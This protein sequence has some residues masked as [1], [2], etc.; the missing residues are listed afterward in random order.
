MMHVLA[1]DPTLYLLDQHDIEKGLLPDNSKAYQTHI[2]EITNWAHT[3]L[4]HSHS[5]LGRDGPVCPYTQP[6]LDRALFWLTVFPGPHP[7]LEEVCA[8]VMKYREWFLELE[9]TTGKDAQYK[10]ILI[11][12][13]DL[14]P[15]Q[16]PNVIDTIQSILKPEF[17]S[18][19]LMIGQFHAN[20][21]EPA[22]WNH[23]FHPLRTT[24]PLLAIRYMVP[25]DFPFLKKDASSLAIYLERFGHAV[26]GRLQTAVHETALKFGL[27]YP[28]T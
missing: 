14:T 12:F 16:A 9:P 22:I 10:A 15:A 4:C 19:G 25:T 17:I 28:R 23:N 1:T 7:I 21:E 11:L 13:P 2:D 24:V 20:C 5:E 26:P 3:Y 8:V 27:E 6:S 18:K